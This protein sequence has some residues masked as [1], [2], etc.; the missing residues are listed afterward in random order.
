[1]KENEYQIKS[2]NIADNS[3]ETSTISK[4]SYEI[5]DANNN[6]FSINRRFKYLFT[7]LLSTFICLINLL[8]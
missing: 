7:I 8:Y 1:M 3:E 2:G 6:C 4:M 5:E